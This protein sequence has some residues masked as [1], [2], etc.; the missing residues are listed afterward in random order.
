MSF[1]SSEEFDNIEVEICRVPLS[2]YYVIP[3]LLREL[4]KRNEGTAE[5]EAM[6]AKFPGQ[7]LVIEQGGDNHF[8]VYMDVEEKEN[9][10]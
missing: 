7:T 5:A 2:L 10:D 3:E 6:F 1:P 9:D 4:I 8:F